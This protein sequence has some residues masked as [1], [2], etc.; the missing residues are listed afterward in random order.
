M[1]RPVAALVVLL[2]AAATVGC[3]PDTTPDGE[4]CAQRALELELTLTAE[5]LEPGAPS[6]CRDQEITLV[7][8]SEVDG[9]LHIHGYDD[10]VPAFQVASGEVTEITFTAGRSGQFAVELHPGDDPR[11]VEVGLFTVHEP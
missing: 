2:V 1:T 4:A 8:T 10:E 6:V 9:V 3:V 5:A 7:V 11:G